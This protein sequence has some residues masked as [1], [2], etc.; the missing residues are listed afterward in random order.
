MHRVCVSLAPASPWPPHRSIPLS[1]NSHTIRAAGFEPAI[2]SSPSL[3]I[4]QAFP[5]PGRSV[6]RPM[7]WSMRPAVRDRQMKRP[8]GH[9]TGPRDSTKGVRDGPGV[10]SADCRADGH[11][12]N[13]RGAAWRSDRSVLAVDSGRS[14]QSRPLGMPSSR[15]AR[16]RRML[17]GPDGRHRRVRYKRDAGAGRDVRAPTTFFLGRARPP[18]IAASACRL[19]LSNRTPFAGSVSAEHFDLK[20]I[21]KPEDTRSG[22]QQSP[23]F[24]RLLPSGKRRPAP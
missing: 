14:S 3:R 22:K 4:S 8:G 19:A 24:V 1:D 18:E 21:V 15:F 11:S 17:R 6:G 7:P 2:S 20:M 9:D 10:N 13:N 5:R 23:R 16:T 12:P